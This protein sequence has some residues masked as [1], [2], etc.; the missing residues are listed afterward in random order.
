MTRLCAAGWWGLE[1]KLLCLG[2]EGLE[3]GLLAMSM[4][5]R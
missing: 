5:I 1:E 2:A 3:G 4:K